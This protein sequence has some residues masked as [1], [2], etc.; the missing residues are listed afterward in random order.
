MTLNFGKM[1][2]KEQAYYLEELSDQMDLASK[3]LDFERA[4]GL[5]DQISTLKQIRKKKKHRI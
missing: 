5:R 1:Q 4:A 3:N 2:K